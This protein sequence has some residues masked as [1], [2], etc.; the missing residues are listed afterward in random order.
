MI[1]NLLTWQLYKQVFFVYVSRRWI[2]LLG[3][4][5]RLLLDGF[6]YCIVDYFIPIV[7]VLMRTRLL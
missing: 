6:K 7:V 5:I 1:D 3:I 4:L 2:I